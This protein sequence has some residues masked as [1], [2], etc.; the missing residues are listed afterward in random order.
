[1]ERATDSLKALYAEA[2]AA[3][4]WSVHVARIDRALASRPT[5]YTRPDLEAV[6][7]LLSRLGV[8]ASSLADDLQSGE[9]PLTD[10]VLALR[11]LER[12]C[13]R[14]ALAH[15]NESR[16]ANG[17][18]P[19][20]WPDEN[21]LAS[22]AR[23]DATRSVAFVNR[24]GRTCLD[25]VEERDIDLLLLEELT[26]EA[27]LQMQLAQ[28]L[29][30]DCS[31][32]EFLEVSN[33]V[34]TASGGESDLI[35]LYSTREGVLALMLE[36]KI[37][38]PFMP[39]QAARYHRR[40]RAGIE[41]GLWDRYLTCL[42]APEAYLQAAHGEHHFD[43]YI[44]YEDLLS[45]FESKRGNPHG[46][47]RAALLQQAIAGARTSTYIRVADDATTIFF[48]EY[49]KFAS[50]EFPALRMPREKDRPA[51]STWVQFRPEAVLPKRVSLWHKARYGT[52]DIMVTGCRVEDL[53][54]AVGDL[55][56]ADMYL[57]QTGKTAVVRILVPKVDASAPFH[58]QQEDVRAALHA[59]ARLAHLL[60]NN[61]TRFR[62]F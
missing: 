44:A 22:A 7:H 9:A 23:G 25:R 17:L 18:Q 49:W 54:S 32:V 61:Q 5:L 57:E 30:D 50:D 27:N 37:G 13:D 62:E 33:S 1:M 35:A 21:H 60:V 10:A 26:S 53:H 43:K 42:V 20:Q 16:I 31:D 58:N 29:L 12:A 59:A 40:G 24:F 34:S 14:L 51:T 28:L 39:D 36:N 38:A 55:L 45:H 2:R 8:F 6:D 4:E 41:E 19:L 46:D 48:R 15:T 47:W 56:A 3:D 52:V 11:Y